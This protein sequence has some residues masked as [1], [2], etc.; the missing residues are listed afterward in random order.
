MLYPK[1]ILSSILVEAGFALAIRKYSLYFAAK[2]E[3]LPF[4][5]QYSSAWQ[6]PAKCLCPVLS[7]AN[8]IMGRV[9]RRVSQRIL[10]ALMNL[11]RAVWCCHAT[12]PLPSSMGTS[13]TRY[14]PRA[15]RFPKTISGAAIAMQ[16]Q[17]TLVARDGHFHEV[18]GLQIEAW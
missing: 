4:M 9:S 16:Y 15:D 7:L 18:D 11:S 14:V 8:S 2:R 6:R 1:K 17:L 5:L 13:K 12:R 10:H 3:D